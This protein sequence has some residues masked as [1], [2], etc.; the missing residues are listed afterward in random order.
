MALLPGARGGAS[1]AALANLG[2]R[3]QA[4]DAGCKDI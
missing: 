1:E 3:E 4:M 2:E